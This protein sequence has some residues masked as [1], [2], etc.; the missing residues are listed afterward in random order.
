MHEHGV[1][2][3]MDCSSLNR[4]Y[5]TLVIVGETASGRSSLKNA[6]RAA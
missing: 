3:Y 2:K 1:E 4:L 6:V 5:N